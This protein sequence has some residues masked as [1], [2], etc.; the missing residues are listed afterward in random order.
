MT[1]NAVVAPTT[2][3][4]PATTK[5]MRLRFAGPCRECGVDQPAGDVAIYD[6]VA[7]NVICVAC[8]SQLAAVSP[9]PPNPLEAILPVPLRASDQASDAERGV[10]AAVEI[11]VGGASARR[12][13]DR[14]KVKD[15]ANVRA[16]EGRI[17]AKHPVLGGLVLAIVDEPVN[18]NT[19]AWATGAHGE[20]IFAKFLDKLAGTGPYFLHDRRIPP[21]KTNIDH[22]VVAPTGVYVIDAKNYTGRATLDVKGGIFTPRVERLL[23]GGRDRTKLVDGVRRQVDKVRELLTRI[24]V[25]QDV[26]VHGMLCFVEGDWPLLGGSFS[27]G[28]FEVLWPKKVRK[29]ITA[30]GPIDDEHLQKIHRALA[31]GFPPA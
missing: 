23:V 3:P 18:P 2:G 11:G 24:G 8:F 29:I 4:I 21:G 20:E 22:I 9:I 13:H 1:D 30:A 14:R 12:E 26:P 15:D 5:R 10:A 27:V 17:R 19:K 31:A 6:K 28:G 16:W 7:K 25:N